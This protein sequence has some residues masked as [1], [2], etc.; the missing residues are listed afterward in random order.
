MEEFNSV[1]K[2]GNTASNKNK[3][4]ENNKKAI[5]METPFTIKALN[6]SR[7]T[8]FFFHFTYYTLNLIIY[9]F[10]RLLYCVVSFIFYISAIIFTILNN[11][12]DTSISCC[13]PWCRNWNWD[14]Y[15]IKTTDTREKFCTIFCYLQAYCFFVLTKTFMDVCLTVPPPFIIKL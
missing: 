7:R 14:W 4:K 13:V 6:S 9:I 12:D 5:C 11:F 3:T 10:I 8:T 15:W 1:R 2:S